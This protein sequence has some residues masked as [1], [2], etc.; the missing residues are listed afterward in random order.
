MSQIDRTKYL[1]SAEL[2]A[3]WN[4]STI[5]LRYWRRKGEGPRYFKPAGR[6][7]RTL[8]PLESIEA[9]EREHTS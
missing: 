5:T 8:Y 1:T 2:A 9:W 3:R 7:G 6:N 4:M